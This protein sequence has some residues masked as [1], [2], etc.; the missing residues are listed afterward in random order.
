MQPATSHPA[1]PPSRWYAAAAGVAAGALGLGVGE[2]VA[3]LLGAT[4]S[5]VVALADRV[6]DLAPQQVKERSVE[7]LGTADKPVLVASVL[8]GTTALLALVGLLGARSYWLGI[9][10]LGVLAVVD[11]AALLADRSPEATPW[12][13]GL[14]WAVALAVTAVA[15]R[16]LLRPWR[17]SA[18]DAAPVAAPPAATPTLAPAEE[19]APPGFDRRRFLL[20]ASAMTAV[21]VAGTWAGQLRTGPSTGRS[22]VVLPTA[23]VPAAPVPS[24]A[25]LGVPGLTPYLTP[26]P[27]FY[28]IDIALRTPR[29]TVEDYRLRIHGLV[30]RP[31]ELSYRDLLD[32]PLVERRVT[33]TC[34]S[35]PVGGEYA[36]NATWLGVRLEDL[37]ARVGVD[38][39]ADAVRSVGADGITIGTPLEALRDGREALLAV[40]MNGEPLPLEHGFPVRMVVPGLYGYV[41]ATK[42]LTELEVTRFEDF[43]AYWT[44]RGWAEQGPIKTATRIDVPGEGAVR[45]GRVSVAGVA[46]AQH[47]G[48]D[49]VEV[50]VDGGAWQAAR[51]ATEDTVDTWRQWVWEWDAEPGR[52]VLEARAVDATGTPQTGEE[53]GVAPDGATG[54]PRREIDVE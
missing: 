9:A 47:R 12:A 36:G 5:P 22:A 25:E 6:I 14:A 48:I 34:V 46:W 16:V 43:S 4:S 33:L 40:G 54:Y 32:L 30:D 51:L 35:N 18:D 26:N 52:H 7:V 41:S 44:E 29:L 15:L 53:A 2:A 19:P 10:L 13:S 31:L 49:A 20:A 3:G 23:A 28:R 24:G 27:D 1:S 50:R 8:V 45:A 38:P 17:A 39:E 37:L 21:G 11:A 42:W